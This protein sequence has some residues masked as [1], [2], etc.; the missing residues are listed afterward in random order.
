[1]IQRQ[2]ETSCDQKSVEYSEDSACL[3]DW[4]KDA[5]NSTKEAQ[6]YHNITNTQHQNQK[7]VGIG[8]NFL[9]LHKKK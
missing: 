7:M 1:V 8:S 2:V 9:F 6:T 4:E 5:E 3:D